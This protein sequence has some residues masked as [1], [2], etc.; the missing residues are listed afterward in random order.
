MKGELIKFLT[1]D[2]LILHGFFS[3]ARNK[4][5]I[6]YV[7][8]LSGNFY[9]AYKTN[10]IEDLAKAANKNGLNFLS[11]N[12][13]GTETISGINKKVGKKHKL[14]V[15]GATYE[16]FEDC[17][18]DIKGAIDFLSKRGI[19][20]VFLVGKSTGCQK[21][22]YYLMK[23][24]DRRVEG[25]ILIAPADDKNYQKKFLKKRYNESIKICEKLI[26]NRK[27]NELMPKWSYDMPVSAQRYHSIVKRTEGDVFDYNKK[28]LKGISRIKVPILV[29]F[30]SK[31]EYA[32]IKP[33]KMF[34]II[35]N[36]SKAR[37]DT[38][39]IK[40]ADHSFAGH[41]NILLKGIFKWIKTL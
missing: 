40:R 30:G 29:I 22:T 33:K 31:E 41:M 32:V 10:M 4:K 20:Q 26:K 13:R 17:I 2:N 5:A 27:G 23:I 6:L 12:T 1:K 24:K 8:G 21:S 18:Y 9:R 35:K 38:L 25:L 16:R 37:C 19:N 3:K 34:E 39:L 14:I 15:T 36:S 7:H 11:I 28:K